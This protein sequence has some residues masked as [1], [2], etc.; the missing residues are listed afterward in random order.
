MNLEQIKQHY[1]LEPLKPYAGFPVYRVSDRLPRL[2]E[3][4]KHC[5]TCL[6]DVEAVPKEQGRLFND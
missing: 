2:A 1:N 5:E 6:C 4:Q 3:D